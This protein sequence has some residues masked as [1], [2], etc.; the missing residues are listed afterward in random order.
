LE[1]LPLHSFYIKSFK[2]NRRTTHPYP[3]AINDLIF[4]KVCDNN[5]TVFWTKEYEK[6]S[7]IRKIQRRRENGYEEELDCG[8]DGFSISD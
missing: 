5:S 8:N 4:F 3:F 6:N 1:F 2:A 7:W